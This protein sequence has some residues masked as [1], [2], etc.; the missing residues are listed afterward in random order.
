MSKPSTDQ[1]LVALA[2]AEWRKAFD[3]G[4]YTGFA[5]LDYLVKKA[6][7]SWNDILAKGFVKNSANKQLQLDALPYNDW[8]K[9]PS[10]ITSD[11][12]MKTTW[13]GR[14]G[15]CTSFTV[16]IVTELEA[17]Y[18]QT[19]AFKIYDLGRHRIARCEKTGVL[20]DSSSLQGAFRLPEDEWTRI[21][22]SEA[23]W[24]WIK[25]ESKFVRQAEQPGVKIVSPVFCFPPFF[26]YYLC[27]WAQLP[28]LG[29]LPSVHSF[30]SSAN[31]A[32]YFRKLPMGENRPDYPTNHLPICL[33][34]YGCP[35]V[36]HP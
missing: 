36:E 19:Y 32:I 3:A 29:A 31:A 34:A 9:S 27:P 11:P 35:W 20:I 23:S 4:P 7:L 18:P 5:M 24:K 22:A 6:G 28:T 21:E 33:P 2:D 13:Q 10:T 14:T 12:T 1:K 25:G 30:F 15:R 8:R 26:C 17:K 16:K